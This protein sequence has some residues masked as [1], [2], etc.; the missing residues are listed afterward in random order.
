MKSNLHPNW[1][2]E[3]Q[4]SCACGNTFST[5][6]TI[7]TIQVDICSKCHP[8]FT[9]EMRFVD[10]QGRVDKFM[11]KVQAAQVKQAAKKQPKTAAPSGP[12]KSYQEI[13]HDQQIRLKQRAAAAKVN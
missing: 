5:G 13:L 8:F 9:G 1:Y 3:A 10:R 7:E 11:Q 2:P 6:S 4:V 12:A